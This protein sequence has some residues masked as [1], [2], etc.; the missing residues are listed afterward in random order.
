[1]AEFRAFPMS[2]IP[3]RTYMRIRLNK[4]IFRQI[5]SPLR[6]RLFLGAF[7][8]AASGDRQRPIFPGNGI[9]GSVR[10]FMMF[11]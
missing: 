6:P 7:G 5:D 10:H 8:S 9:G 1:M 3:R 4:L 11:S 2:S